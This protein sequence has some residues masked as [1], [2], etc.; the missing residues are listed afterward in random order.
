[1]PIGLRGFNSNLI[2]QGMNNSAFGIQL[3]QRSKCARKMRVPTM[4][5]IINKADNTFSSKFRYGANLRFLRE[6]NFKQDS[7]GAASCRMD[8]ASING[9]EIQVS[10]FLILKSDLNH[11]KTLKELTDNMVTNDMMSTIR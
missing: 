5:R 9:D 2:M 7:T 11:I 8:D 3:L 6:Q 10:N 4:V 1:M